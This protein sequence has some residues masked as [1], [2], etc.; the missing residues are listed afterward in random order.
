MFC[1]ETTLERKSKHYKFVTT[2]MM[3]CHNGEE[4]YMQG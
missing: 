3:L 2:V 1:D 4:A